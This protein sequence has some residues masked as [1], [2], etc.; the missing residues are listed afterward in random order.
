MPIEGLRKHLNKPISG[1]H[2]KRSHLGLKYDKW[3]CT[4]KEIEILKNNDISMSDKMKKLHRGHCT[5]V[6]KMEELGIDRYRSERK[7]KKNEH[8]YPVCPHC[9]SPNT[10][11]HS[12]EVQSDCIKQIYKCHGCN[13]SWRVPIANIESTPLIS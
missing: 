8:E 13:R 2:T 12:K 11:K 1:I 9:G 3:N 7:S 10:F 4:E 5:I 6:D